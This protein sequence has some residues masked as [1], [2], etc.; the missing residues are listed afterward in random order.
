VADLG[1]SAKKMISRILTILAVLVFLAFT[2]QM[3]WLIV[4]ELKEGV[5][6]AGGRDYRK[7]ERPVS[8]WT[9][10]GAHFFFAGLFLTAVI[11]GVNRMIK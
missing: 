11:I 7:K 5:A 3:M 6:H 2:V 4:S 9:S 1:R 10:I 8:Y